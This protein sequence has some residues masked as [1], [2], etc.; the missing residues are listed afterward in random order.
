MRKKFVINT[1]NIMNSA[2]YSEDGFNDYLKHLIN[3]AELNDTQ[4]GIASLVLD[5]GY[6]VL[7]DKQRYVFDKM[8][9]ENTVSSCSLCGDSIPGCEMEFA[10]E[11]DGLCIHCAKM[12]RK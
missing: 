8:I 1:Q 4:R 10:M 3:D 12:L 11:H 5:K 9:D 7:T 6:D 2:R